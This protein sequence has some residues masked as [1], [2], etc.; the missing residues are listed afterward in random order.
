MIVAAVLVWPFIALMVLWQAY[1]SMSLW[2]WFVVPFGLP[3]L[4]IAWAIGISCVLMALKP[5][6]YVANPK[7]GNFKVAAI[8]LLRPFLN[9]ALALFIGWIA[10]QWMPTP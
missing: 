4:T 10:L 8:G 6:P 2:G 5:N 9:P 1:V 3:P 7:D